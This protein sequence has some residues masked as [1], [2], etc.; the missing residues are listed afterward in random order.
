MTDLLDDYD[1]VIDQDPEVAQAVAN[2]PP[3]DVEM[4]DE[5]APGAH[6][7]PELL[8]HGFDQHFGRGTATPVPGSESPVTPRDDELL[9]S[10]DGKTEKA[11]GN[12]RPGSSPN[13]DQTPT[14]QK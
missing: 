12:G 13:S 1:E 9:N 2:I 5:T 7:N 10:P 14:E 8:Q 4:R 11:P 3:P 6:F